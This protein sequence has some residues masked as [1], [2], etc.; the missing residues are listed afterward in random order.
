MEGRKWEEFHQIADLSGEINQPEV[1]EK[2]DLIIN[3]ALEGVADD[4][5][6]AAADELRKGSELAKLALDKIAAAAELNWL[7]PEYLAGRIAAAADILGHASAA[8]LGAEDLARAQRQ[9]YAT[10][11]RI[12]ADGPMN[13]ASLAALM[14]MSEAYI[15]RRLAELRKARL[16]VAQ[17]RGRETVNLLTPVARLIVEKG[18]EGERRAPLNESKVQDFAARYDL[19]RR[20]PANADLESTDLPRLAV[21]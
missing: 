8:T 16:I 19:N 14:D 10:I 21:S 9:P 15:C 18:V 12:L 2:I 13:N 4:L 5:P 7:S 17:K 3:A 6:L 1:S 20:A 11:L